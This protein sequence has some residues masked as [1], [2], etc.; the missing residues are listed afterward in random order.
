[1]SGIEHTIPQLKTLNWASAITTK[2]NI[3]NVT[4]WGH[5]QPLQQCLINL[6]IIMYLL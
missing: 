5:Q 1:L 4:C 3:K 6:L 2:I